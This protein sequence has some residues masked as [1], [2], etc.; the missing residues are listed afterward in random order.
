MMRHIFQRFCAVAASGPWR[1]LWDSQVLRHLNGRKSGKRRRQPLFD[2]RLRERD[3]IA[4]VHPPTLAD[5]KRRGYG[6]AG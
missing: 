6:G 4:A 3:A 5:L 2:E 1:R